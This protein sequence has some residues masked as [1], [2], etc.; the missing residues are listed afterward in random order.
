MLSPVAGTQLVQ[1]A[2][3]TGRLLHKPVFPA[4]GACSAEM[5]SHFMNRAFEIA[6]A[7]HAIRLKQGLMLAV[8]RIERLTDVQVA[9]FQQGAELH[10]RVA[11]PRWRDEERILG[12]GRRNGGDALVGYPDIGFFAFDADEVALELSGD[13]ASGAGA[14]EGIEDD[15]AGIAGCQ[16]DAIEQRLRLLRRVSFFAID[17]DA[18]RAGAKRNLSDVG[19]LLFIIEVLHGVIIEGVALLLL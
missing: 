1:A 16:D 17:L 12:G 5:H 15:I 10:A 4:V 7:Q 2:Q 9:R 6:R 11:A 8:T 14:E 19:H 13:R 3:L 18:L